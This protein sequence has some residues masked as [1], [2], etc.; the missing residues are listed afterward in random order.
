MVT[1]SRRHVL[2]R[3]DATQCD[4]HGEHRTYSCPMRA[5][6][7]GCGDVVILPPYSSA[8]DADEEDDR[9]RP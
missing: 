4:A 6:N 5:G 2:V 3:W 8:C 7:R 1:C 9:I